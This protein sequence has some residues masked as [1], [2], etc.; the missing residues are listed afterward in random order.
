[1]SQD[2]MRNLHAIVDVARSVDAK[3]RIDSPLSELLEL[4]AQTSEDPYG[5]LVD[6]PTWVIRVWQAKRMEKRIAALEAEIER[7]KHADE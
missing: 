7:L 6:L 5:V 1:M 3:A 2:T 4:D